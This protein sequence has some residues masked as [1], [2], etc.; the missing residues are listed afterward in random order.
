MSIVVSD[1]SPIRALA[2]LDLLGILPELF[3]EV[4]VPSAVA[5]ELQSDNLWISSIDATQVAGLRIVDPPASP[6]S[7]SGIEKLDPGETAAIALAL[8]L[9][10][11]VLMDESFGREVA[12]RL[13]LTVTGTLGVLLL[14]KQF[15]KI[16]AVRPL[17]DRLRTEMNFFVAPSLYQQILKLAGET[18][19]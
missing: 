2:H 1:T 17:V 13:G 3:G 8:E 16:T 11:I 12:G 5:R 14:A 7:L 18:A 10:A 4:L 15:Q 6:A 19:Q 9:Q